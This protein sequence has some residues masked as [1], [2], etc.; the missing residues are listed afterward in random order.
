MD[1]TGQEVCINWSDFKAS[2]TIASIL[3]QSVA[4]HNERE[5]KN[6]GRYERG[7]TATILQDQL[8]AF[9]IDSGNDY[10]GL[11]RWYWY[12]VEGEPGHRTYTMT[13]YEPC[14]NVGIGEYMVYTQQERYTQEKRL[15]NKSKIT[16]P[17]RPPSSPP[18]VASER[19]QSDPHYGCR[20]KR[21]GWS[22]V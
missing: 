5:T 8:A 4:S 15:Q 17:R 21:L 12:P 18:K 20:Q 14:G 10:T 16:F 2:Q 11:G 7:G 19:R 22:D 9:I 6:V 3:N 13:A 1:I